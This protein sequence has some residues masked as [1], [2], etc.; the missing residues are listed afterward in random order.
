MQVVHAAIGDLG[1]NTSHLRFRLS[2]VGRAEF[3]SAQAALRP[4]EPGSIFRRVTGITDLLTAVGDQQVFN[5]CVQ[6]NGVGRDTQDFGFKIAQHRYEVPTCTISGNG[7]GTG[8]AGKLPAPA[9]VQGLLALGDIEFSIPVPEGAVGQLK[10]LPVLFLL[11]YGVSGA[12]FEEVCKSPLLVPKAL[13]KRY[14]RDI[15]QPRKLTGL[16][17][18]GQFFTRLLVTDFLPPQSKCLGSPV[19]HLVI[20]KSD[21]PEG[22]GKKRF[23]FRRWV[24]AVFHGSLGHSYNILNIYTALKSIPKFSAVL[25]RCGPIVPLS[26][27]SLKEGAQSRTFRRNG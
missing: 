22:P 1:V 21:T 9:N 19:E 4:G 27:T 24:K 18:P 17:H 14:T 6:P 20:D 10:A 13:L 11:E 7:D 8:F 5:S 16:F 26:L 15:V 12:P 2:T 25:R 3:L 23:L